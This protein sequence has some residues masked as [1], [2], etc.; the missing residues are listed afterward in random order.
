LGSIV[1]YVG[2]GL[3]QVLVG[4]CPAQHLRT[5]ESDERDGKGGSIVRE[6][7]GDITGGLDD[8]RDEHP[9]WHAQG[10]ERGLRQ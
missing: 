4:G 5:P 6:I 2:Y 9:M 7:G 3:F 1:R 10:D 8:E